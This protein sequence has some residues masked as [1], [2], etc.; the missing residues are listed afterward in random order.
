EGFSGFIKSYF[1]LFFVSALFGRIMDDCGAVRKVALSIASVT[2]RSRRPK[3]WTLCIMPLFYAFLGYSGINGFVC[4][5]TILAIGRELFI[6]CDIP[7]RLYPVGSAGMQPAIILGGSIY[8]TNIIVADNFGT[9]LTAMMGLSVVCTIVCILAIGVCIHWELRKFEKRN[10]GF[11]PSGEAIKSMQIEAPRPMEELPNII[12]AVIPL[13]APVALI[14]IFKIDPIIG[15]LIGSALGL[16][17]NFKYLKSIRATINNGL[18]SAGSPIINTC[19][20]VG[21]VAIIRLTPGF[22]TLIDTLSNLPGVFSGVSLVMLMCAVVG[23]SSTFLPSTLPVI[24]EKFAEAGI[25]NELAHRLT[26]LGITSY[27]T[28]HNSGPVNA[29]TL[30]KLNIREVAWLYF[31]MTFIPGT[32][33]LAVALIAYGFG[34]VH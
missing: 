30:C 5:F 10:E 15:L 9:P 17:M 23:S 26:T 34:I 12:C 29:I 13:I 28:P 3:F 4:I 19:G 18:L 1:L 21:F 14:I 25:S 24:M 31:K 6:E 22:Q 20:A 16:I 2:K 32:A 11:L 7:W 27:M 8:I 33:A